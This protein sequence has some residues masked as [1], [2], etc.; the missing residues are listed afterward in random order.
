MVYDCFGPSAVFVNISPHIQGSLFENRQ[1]IFL[2]NKIW[3]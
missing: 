1:E 3:F 2:Q